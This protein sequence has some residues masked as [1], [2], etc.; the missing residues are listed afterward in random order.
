MKKIVVGSKNPVKINAVARAAKKFWSNVNVIGIDCKSNISSMPLSK[1]EVRFGAK[2]R[3]LKASQLSN[4]DLGC[5]L[6]G[7]VIT[8]ENIHYLFS[9]TIISDGTKFIF[10][11]ETLIYLP[12]KIY[13]RLEKGSKELGQV[14]DELLGQQNTKQ[15][16]GAVGY[17]TDNRITRTDVFYNSSIMALAAWKDL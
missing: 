8:I 12:E 1:Q 11:G 15:K 10:G 4:A 2:N 13:I 7:G 16:D 5:G 14:M 3:A 17:L 6:E 9:S